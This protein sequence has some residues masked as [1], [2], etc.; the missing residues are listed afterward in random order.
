[1]FL[2]HSSSIGQL[3]SSERLFP[4]TEP[5]QHKSLPLS[6]GHDGWSAA[7]DSK[8]NPAGS[9]NFKRPS[10][11]MSAWKVKGL[12]ALF[13]GLP[14]K[15]TAVTPKKQPEGETVAS[16]FSPQKS[17]SVRFNRAARLSPSSDKRIRDKISVTDFLLRP[18]PLTVSQ[19]WPQQ[20]AT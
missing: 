2:L 9:H 13:L 1:M 12:V 11:E 3:P 17:T 18:P 14:H 5:M 19:T 10:S 6:D 8:R 20:K 7:E 16:L 15:P 4:H